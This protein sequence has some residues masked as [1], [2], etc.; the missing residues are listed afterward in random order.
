[1]NGVNGSPE[2][3][4]WGRAEQPGDPGTLNHIFSGLTPTYT[5][6]ISASGGGTFTNVVPGQYRLSVYK[7]GQ[8]G[9]YR[10]DSIIVVANQT[11]TALQ[12]LLSN[13]KPLAR[14][15]GRRLELLT[16]LRTN[17]LH[18]AN[19]V[20]NFPMTSRWRASMIANTTATGTTGSTGQIPLLQERRFIT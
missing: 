9:E 17:S 8:F 16:A 15:S 7:F 13:L 10:N 3:T 18:G 4:A 1:M 6:D 19:T 14:C 5:M 12:R 11:T 2:L 20:R